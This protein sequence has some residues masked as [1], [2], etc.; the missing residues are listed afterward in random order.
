MG[1]FDPPKGGVRT[2]SQSGS[3]SYMK[4]H[5]KRQISSKWDAL[6]TKRT[7]LCYRTGLIWVSTS[8]SIRLFTATVATAAAAGVNASVATGQSRDMLYLD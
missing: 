1:A 5:I 4:D 7:F 2:I 8:P 3:N 6:I